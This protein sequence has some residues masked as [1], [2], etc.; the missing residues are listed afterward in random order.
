MAMNA[1]RLKEENRRYRGT[2]GVSE[3]NRS[4]GFAPAFLDSESGAIHPSCL[5][6]GSPAPCHCLDGL[7]APLVTGRDASGRVVA[8]RSC[9]VAGFVRD[10]VFYTREQAARAVAIAECGP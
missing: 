10:G 7:P 1:A 4:D 6:D 9:V 2:G 8:V 3:R 5:A